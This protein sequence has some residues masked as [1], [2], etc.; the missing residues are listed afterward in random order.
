[1]VYLI[2]EIQFYE[3]SRNN[4]MK[5]SKVS[6]ILKIICAAWPTWLNG[7]PLTYEHLIKYVIF[8]HLILNLSIVKIGPNLSP[9]NLIINSKQNKESVTKSHYDRGGISFWKENNKILALNSVGSS[10]WSSN[11]QQLFHSVSAGYDTAYNC[12]PH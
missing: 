12:V 2:L 3:F 5:A 10:E 6:E 4:T 7:W 11:S 8:P 9:N 1:M